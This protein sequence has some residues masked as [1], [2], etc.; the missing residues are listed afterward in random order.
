[1]LD[2]QH[3][4]R[5]GK[6]L[7]IIVRHTEYCGGANFVTDAGEPL[8]VGVLCYPKDQIVSPHTHIEK[9]LGT[10]KTM[11][12]LYIE[13]GKVECRIYDSYGDFVMATDLEVG[14]ILVQLSGGHAFI[15]Q[16]DAKIIEVK[17]GPYSGRQEDKRLL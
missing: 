2:I 13:S 5:A 7:A 3:I 16:E 12:V 6:Q 10:S 1:M 17:Q 15:I 4:G 9:A 8:Q 11:E 14:D